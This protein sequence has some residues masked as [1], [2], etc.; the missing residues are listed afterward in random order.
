[1]T[2][3]ARDEYTYLHRTLDKHPPPE[4]L[5]GSSRLRLVDTWRLGPLGFVWAAILVKE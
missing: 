1:M 2:I 5:L 4:T 3:G